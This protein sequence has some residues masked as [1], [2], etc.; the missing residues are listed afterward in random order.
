MTRH[1]IAPEVGIEW[2]DLASD[3]APESLASPGR[4]VPQAF[5]PAELPKCG[6]GTAPTGPAADPQARAEAE[7]TAIL[8]RPGHGRPGPEP[9]PGPSWRA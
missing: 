3:P 8:M 4:S 2:D 7:M 1:A 9:G 5:S 6:T